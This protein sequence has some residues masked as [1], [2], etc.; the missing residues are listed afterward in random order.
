MGVDT[1]G[2]GGR[3]L[4]LVSCLTT[5]LPSQVRRLEGHHLGPAV[6]QQLLPADVGL[7]SQVLERGP[8]HGLGALP[9]M[10]AD[11]TVQLHTQ[12]PQLFL[13]RHRGGAAREVGQERGEG[14]GKCWGTWQ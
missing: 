3:A 12:Q 6:G 7:R 1:V 11:V 8:V 5:S 10:G 4:A 2:A 14:Q 9:D 13:Q